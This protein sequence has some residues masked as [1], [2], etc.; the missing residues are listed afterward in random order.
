[1]PRSG[2]PADGPPEALA[3]AIRDDVRSFEAGHPPADDLTR[4]ALG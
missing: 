3:T 1:M 4:P 2:G